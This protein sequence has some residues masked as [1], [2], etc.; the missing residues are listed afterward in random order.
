MKLF[1]GGWMFNK[2]I[3]IICILKFWVYFFKLEIIL[4]GILN[5]DLMK[6]SLLFRFDI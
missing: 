1:L 5:I 6:K 2:I 3:R 4:L